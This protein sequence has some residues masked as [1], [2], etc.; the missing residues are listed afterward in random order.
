H[1]WHYTLPD[2]EGARTLSPNTVVEV[3]W[4][5]CN[6]VG[7]ICQVVKSKA[8]L[9][10]RRYKQYITIGPYMQEAQF[11]FQQLPTPPQYKDAFGAIEHEGI[12]CLYGNWLIKG[13]PFT[14]LINTQSS[15]ININ[16]VKKELWEKYGVDSL[17]AGH[18]Y[19]EPLVW[20]WAA[21]KL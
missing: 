20:S 6:K 16:D 13:E 9:I 3:S 11:E 15:H 10:K 8:D 18:D 4:E 5:V 14:I 19:E 17:F 1:T 7:G 21:G 2:C 12:I